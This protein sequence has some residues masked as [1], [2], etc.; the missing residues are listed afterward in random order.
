MPVDLM[1]VT[2]PV[3]NDNVMRYN[4]MLTTITKEIEVSIVKTALVK[5]IESPHQHIKEPPLNN[6][7]VSFDDR[8]QFK[9]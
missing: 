7:L 8:E 1:K 4:Q 2:I 5:R 6:L 3:L 9:P